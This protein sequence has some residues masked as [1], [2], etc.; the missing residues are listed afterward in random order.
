MQ[1]FDIVPK[2]KDNPVIGGRWVFAMK[3]NEHGETIYKARYVAKGFSQIPSLNYSETFSPTA[4]F[5]SIRTLCQVAINE[6][7]KIY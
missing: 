4:R 6:N 5:T 2:P 7:M 3:N 1:T